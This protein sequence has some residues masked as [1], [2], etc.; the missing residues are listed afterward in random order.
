LLEVRGSL[1]DC[2]SRRRSILCVGRK[3]ETFMHQSVFESRI[4]SSAWPPLLSGL[5]LIASLGLAACGA[6]SDLT[7][8]STA[9]RRSPD[10]TPTPTPSNTAS[11]NPCAGLLGLFRH[12]GDVTIT[13]QAEADQYAGIREIVGNLTIK[14]GQ[15]FLG[16]VGVLKIYKAGLTFSMPDL[17]TVSGNVDIDAQHVD[18]AKLSQLSLITG[19][20][21]VT[22]RSYLA[23]SLTQYA[24]TI[25]TLKTPALTEVRGSINA[26]GIRDPRITD[27]AGGAPYDFGLDQIVSVGTDLGGGNFVGGDVSIQGP[28]SGDLLGLRGLV[29]IPGDL[30]IIWPGANDLS[31]PELLPKV[32]SV[33][34]SLRMLGT[35]N[36]DEL[37]AKLRYIGKDLT[38]QYYN[39]TD[40]SNHTKLRHGTTFPKLEE[41]GRDLV[42]ER[43]SPYDC[44]VP[45]LA[46]LA[47]VNGI[48]HLEDVQMQ[49][50]FGKTGAGG[51][52]A[53]GIEIT[54]SRG[55]PPFFSDLR[56]APAATV[57]IHDN[58]DLCRC[59]IDAF[60]DA[61]NSAGWPGVID[62]DNNGDCDVCPQC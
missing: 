29:N 8:E 24:R 14:A 15:K 36:S 50:V 61:L 30:E 20:L 16:N 23:G 53:G 46:S 39:I 62:G 41:V 9:S 25:A 1:K 34:G 22:L 44:N 32:D 11:F 4:H 56:L 5:L 42:L 58:P 7:E 27:A 47:R 51:L 48:I 59:T 31:A 13:S 6:E 17:Q 49:G 55:A 40:P 26:L 10:A 3:A 57:S 33:G 12:C 37:M 19:N 54:G 60:Q 35:S 52:V 45:E 18:W 28:K 2:A 43:T 21:K 38:F